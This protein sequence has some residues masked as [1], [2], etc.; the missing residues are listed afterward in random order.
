MLEIICVRQQ[1]HSLILFD[2]CS[3][4][5]GMIGSL[6]SNICAVATCGQSEDWY[7]WTLDEGQTKGH[8]T[9]G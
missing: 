8:T 5:M 3:I 6:G 4:L 9:D 7:V 1:Q 2:K